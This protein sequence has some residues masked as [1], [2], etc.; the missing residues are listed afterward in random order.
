VFEVDQPGP[1]SWKRQLFLMLFLTL[2]LTLA[3]P[4]FVT[5]V[6]GRGHR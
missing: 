1:Q 2:A 3:L 6:G 4:L 5:L